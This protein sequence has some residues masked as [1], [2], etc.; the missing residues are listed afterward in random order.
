M[1]EMTT[2]QDC[3]WHSEVDSAVLFEAGRMVHTTYGLLL[4]VPDAAP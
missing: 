4:P 2:D 3:Y 1:V